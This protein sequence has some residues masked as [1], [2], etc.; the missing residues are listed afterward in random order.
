MASK[1][2]LTGITVAVLLTSV[3][4]AAGL[5]AM[6]KPPEKKEESVKPF[7]SQYNRLFESVGR[8]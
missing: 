1:L 8:I 4:I 7:K 6:K 5:G 2:K 3:G